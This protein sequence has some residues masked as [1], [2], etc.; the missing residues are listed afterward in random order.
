V[1]RVAVDFDAG[2]GASAAPISAADLGQASNTGQRQKRRNPAGARQKGR[3]AASL[4]RC[5]PLKGMRLARFL[6][7]APSASTRDPF[8]YFNSLLKEG[9]DR[10]DWKLASRD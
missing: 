10:D 3:L 8:Q 4:A 7:S 6:P 9:S 5:S 2:Q 1:S